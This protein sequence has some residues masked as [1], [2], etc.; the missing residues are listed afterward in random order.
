MGA[1]VILLP[2]HLVANF[3]AQLQAMA[4]V[5]EASA[6]CSRLFSADL[7]FCQLHVLDVALHGNAT[8]PEQS[9]S[10]L[11]KLEVQQQLPNPPLQY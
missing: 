8:A 2:R 11:R 10:Q 3:E 7:T 6:A 5:I 9:P 4:R 1:T